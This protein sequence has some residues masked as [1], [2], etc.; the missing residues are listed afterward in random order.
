MKDNYTGFETLSVDS[1][2][3]YRA[4]GIQLRHLVTGAQV[5]KV[6]ADDSENLISYIFRTPPRNH[7]GVA[8]ILE[9]SVLCGS[10][11]YPLKDPFLVLLKG[12]AHTFLNAITYPDKTVYP[13]ASTIKAD[14]I[15]LLRVYGD[16][17]FFPRLLPEVFTQEG[18]RLE[19]DE[20]GRLRRAG[21]VLNEMKGAYSSVEAVVEDYGLRLLFPDS[22][23]G[24][25][26]GGNPAHIPSLGYEE[27]RA[28]H[29]NYYHPSNARIFLYGD[30]DLEETLQIL[31]G[32]FL[33]HFEKKEID[34]RIALQRRWEK[35]QRVEV[36]WPCEDSTEERST[37]S[38]SWLL[39]GENDLQSALGAQVL[40]CILLG[41][42][43]APLQKAII[44]SGLGEDISPVS[45]LDSN[46]RQLVFSVGLRGMNPSKRN[47]F[48][49]LV[50]RTLESLVKEK[51]NPEL[52][53]GAI[54]LVEF[55]MREIRGGSP[56]GLRLMKQA[57]KAWLHDRAPIESL[58]LEGPMEA[59]RGRVRKG[60][61]EEII[62]REL[63]QNPHRSMLTVIPSPRLSERRLARERKE[64]D[65][66]QKQEVN[67]G[68]L[69]RSLKRLRI[70]QNT[71]DSKEALSRIPFLKRNQL[72]R[73]VRVL[74]LEKADQGECYIHTT[75][76]NKVSYLVLAF[77]LT[78]LDA[79]LQPWLP[80]FGR[81][82]TDVGLPGVPHQDVAVEL[83]LR[84][85]GLGCSLDVSSIHPDSG[86]GLKRHLFVRLK[87]L[88]RQWEEALNIT[89]RL[90]VSADFSNLNRLGD[91]LL[92][93]RND[94]RAILIPSGHDFS[95]N[96]AAAKHS[97]AASWED[98]WYG[99]EQICFLGKAKATEATSALS[100]IQKHLIRQGNLS[101]V[102]TSDE[103][104]VTKGFSDTL[105]MISGLP[106]GISAPAT[107]EPKLFKHETLGEII[108]VAA[109][110]TFSSLSLPASLLGSPEHARLGL[111]A[112]ILRTGYLWENIRMKGG[113]Y[114][115]FATLAVLEGTFTF[116]TY[117]D[118]VILPTLRS[119]RDSLEW[120]ISEL[121]KRTV[122]M[123]VI[124]L[125]G[126]ELQ[127]L[128]PSEKGLVAFRRHL[129][130]I[131]DE[132]R[133][134]RRDI[135]LE[136]SAED[137]KRE[138]KSLLDKWDSR[139]ITII[140]GA[141]LLDIATAASPELAQSQ[142]ELP[143]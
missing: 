104:F 75:F 114:G 132:I 100:E 50:I 57:L 13:A 137:L 21:V 95:S 38:L 123:A 87:A 110:V 9:H 22:P 29:Q 113:A 117:R 72:P 118:P 16:A 11:S 25:D 127:P 143:P 59:L 23:Y 41:H 140:G 67:A 99:I 131:T 19:Y 55:R 122:D 102:F 42:G 92:E 129:Y 20:E 80:L 77:D 45:G 37:I 30:A 33:S 121:G 52:V 51:L 138:A 58:A 8:H 124:G 31:D 1:L 73:E 88:N 134:S 47:D 98:L 101:A 133:Q 10:R 26:S 105:N 103:D 108:S 34:S 39:G 111:L 91:L 93:L 79:R 40:S 119:F 44:D 71:P 86:G 43:G 6:H 64:L 109:P 18:H 139:S 5:Y 2:R 17:V 14:Y 65:R 32:E 89:Q 115:A 53:E 85:G 74:S 35:P 96:R 54:R 136:A 15:N 135:Q 76:T 7:S 62:S 69:Q 60:Y 61:F 82:L 120:A 56:F 3:E 83:S 107:D 27:F 128:G 81:A 142:V 130:G 112:H 141:N 28:F 24:W 46:L 63:I 94:Y 78:G 70:F 97:I 49:K 4:T 125:I 106:T 126:K 66:L 48:E 116:S 36:A 90:L 12:S 68:E 84:T